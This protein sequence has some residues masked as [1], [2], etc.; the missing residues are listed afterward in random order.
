MRLVEFLRRAGSAG[1]LLAAATVAA[2]PAGVAG[3]LP[4]VEHVAVAI[5]QHPSVA[6]A[7]AGNRRRASGAP[8]WS[9]KGVS[10]VGWSGWV[11]AGGAT[12]RPSSTRSRSVRDTASRSRP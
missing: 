3:D 7:R 9:K 5:E 8:A 2:Q 4:P 12:G 11:T 1:A 10:I 6:G